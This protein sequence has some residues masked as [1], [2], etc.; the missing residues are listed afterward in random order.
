MLLQFL[1]PGSCAHTGGFIVFGSLTYSKQ[2]GGCWEPRRGGQWGSE[3]AGCS[4]AA[5]QWEAGRR[6]DARGPVRRG[7][8]AGER[9]CSV[10]ARV[11]GSS[12]PAGHREEGGGAGG[13]QDVTEVIKMM[14]SHRHAVFD[15]TAPCK[16]PQTLLMPS[17]SRVIGA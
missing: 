13:G 1:S 8:A 11:S 14:S 6:C 9:G 10:Y 16:S 12:W 4:D 5:L 17:V 15:R 2:P 3:G 7:S